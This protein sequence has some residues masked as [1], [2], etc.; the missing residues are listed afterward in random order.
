MFVNLSFHFMCPIQ[1]KSEEQL[2][3]ERNWISDR[4]W[5][6]HKGGFTGAKVHSRDTS[7]DTKVRITL[8]GTGQSLDVEEEDLEKVRSHINPFTVSPTCICS[9]VWI[10]VIIHI[11]D[12]HCAVLAPCLYQC[13]VWRRYRESSSISPPVVWLG[14]LWLSLCDSQGVFSSVPN[15]Y[16]KYPHL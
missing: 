8:D 6:V 1:A 3:S 9:F 5:L 15:F 10:S 14:L 2:E 16:L 11:A 12:I 7:S 13:I 4:V